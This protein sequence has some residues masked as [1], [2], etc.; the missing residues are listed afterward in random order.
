[1]TYLSALFL[2]IFTLFT[3]KIFRI[4]IWFWHAE[5]IVLLFKICHQVFHPVLQ[6]INFNYF[7]TY[8]M[9]ISG[10][11]FCAAPGVLVILIQ[12]IDP[13]EH[14]SISILL[15]SENQIKLYQSQVAIC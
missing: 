13:E 15:S 8:L 11:K 12:L 10:D 3:H 1:M 6:Y 7:I 2:Y 14:S 9:T 4:V 5:S